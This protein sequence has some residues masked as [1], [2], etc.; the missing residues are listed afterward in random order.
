[1]DVGSLSAPIAASKPACPKSSV[2]PLGPKFL[3]GVEQAATA[4]N[5]I[6][7]K[8]D[9]RTRVS[10]HRNRLI[11]AQLNAGADPTK[12]QMQVI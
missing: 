5:G 2:Q 10:F 8:N 6:S 12:G 3:P 4:K 11:T 1:M 7:V 9:N